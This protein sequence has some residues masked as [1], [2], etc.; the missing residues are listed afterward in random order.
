MKK[1]D[2]AMV[3]L[4]ERNYESFKTHGIVILFNESIQ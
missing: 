2:Y 1:L 3:L 4:L